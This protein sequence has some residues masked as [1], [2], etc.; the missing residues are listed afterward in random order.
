MAVRQPTLDDVT[1]AALQAAFTQLKEGMSKH[2]ANI[3]NATGKQPVDVLTTLY[4]AEKDG[5]VP[6]EGMVPLMAEIHGGPEAMAKAMSEIGVE[7]RE[8]DAIPP[9][10]I[11]E[12]KGVNMR[13]YLIGWLLMFRLSTEE[14]L[15]WAFKLADANG[16]EHIDR[17][18]VTW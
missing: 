14:K 18:Y 8:Q 16:D 11:E 15:E 1:V 5:Y 10:V 9:E 17:K 3:L 12:G 7:G 13:K 2:W 4:N 6:L